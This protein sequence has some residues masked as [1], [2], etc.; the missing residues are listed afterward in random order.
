M[1]KP[2]AIRDRYVREGQ[3]RAKRILAQ[4]EIV[5]KSLR[6]QT[7]NTDPKSLVFMLGLIFYLDLDSKPEREQELFP[8]GEVLVCD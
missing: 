2:K 4:E 1:R 5:G 8:G 6:T 3:V 7:P